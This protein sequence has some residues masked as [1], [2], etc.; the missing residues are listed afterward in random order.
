MSGSG[1]EDA[2]QLKEAG[3][4]Q[5]SALSPDHVAL[6]QGSES[7]PK[8]YD[9][10]TTLFIVLSHDCDVTNDSFYIEPFV[11]LLI[12][13]VRPDKGE[14]NL[15]HG[16]NPRNYHLFLEVDLEVCYECSV[17]NRFR[18]DRRVLLGY[19]P[20]AYRTLDKNLL[21]R[22]RQW[23]A[24]RYTRDAFPDSFNE[25]TREAQKFVEKKQKEISQLVVGIYLFLTDEELKDHEAYE[26]TITGTMLDDDY[27]DLTKRTLANQYLLDLA[28]AFG[29]HTGINVGE[30]FL[31]S[32]D[33]LTVGDTRDLK[34]WDTDS[35]SLRLDPPSDVPPYE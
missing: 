16:K 6:L 3:W 5:G 27:T 14:G 2:S 17:H 31:V 22:V 33:E 1:D 26:I 18:A 28:N 35:L 9:P 30:T 25:R 13:T 19:T 7:L 10:T 15:Y 23:I 8:N 21:T 4:R 34:R 24:R 32:E 29:K 12:A 20:D 11:E